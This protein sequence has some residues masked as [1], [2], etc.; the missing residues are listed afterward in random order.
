MKTA[1]VW[2][3][4]GGIGTALVKLLVDTGWEVLS[5]ARDAG[6]VTALTSY[7]LEV[8]VADPEDVQQAVEQAEGMVGEV[9]LWIYTVGDNLSA[10]IDEMS[11]E[12]WG[13]IFDANLNGAF[14]AVHYSLPLLADDAHIVFL[15]AVSERLR[16]PGLSAYA[17]SKAGLE[18]LGDVLRKEQRGRRVTVVRPK[19]VETGLWDKVPFKVPQGALAPEELAEGILSAYKEGHDGTLDF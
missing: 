4:S 2:G 12:D 13:R 15:G 3:A 5:V 18:A 1:M 17:A 14:G 19:A 10:K 16:L 6:A 11:F 7:A 9:N 8:N